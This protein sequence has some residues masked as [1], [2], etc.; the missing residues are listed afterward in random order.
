MKE[1]KIANHYIDKH[2]WDHAAKHEPKQ[3]HRHHIIHPS[4]PEKKSSSLIKNYDYLFLALGIISILIVTF[5]IVQT[6]SLSSI[7]DGKVAEAKEA[8]IPA[9]I[10]LITIN[11]AQCEDCF[12]ISPLIDSLKKNNVKITDEK[13]LEF[14]SPAAREIIQKYDLKKIPAMLISGEIDK[15]DIIN[16]E[17]RDGLLIFNDPELPYTEAETGE[18]LGLVSTILLHDSSCTTCRDL[19]SIT[20]TLTQ[21]G[22][23][24]KQKIINSSENEAQ[25]L[26]K[27]LNLEK[28]PVFLISEDVE[29]YPF[30]E[31][32]KQAGVTKK[33]EYYVFESPAPYLD[34]KTGDLRGLVDLTM[35]SDSAC[36]ECYDVNLHKN[37]FSQIGFAIADV[38]TID[39]NSGEG[40]KLKNRYALEKVPTVMLTG[41]IGA[42]VD[43]DKLWE[44]VGT[45]DDGTYIFRNIEALGEGIIY[46][47]LN[48]GEI[49]G[50]TAELSG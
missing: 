13:E 1:N 37:L 7:I 28:L 40:I 38:K 41:D 30:V 18:V 46:H 21:S 16:M 19:S 44:Q 49:V 23:T 29:A 24:T 25:E 14:D 9:N 5:N 3:D 12:S 8:A 45:I 39:I 32:I 11:N 15:I 4:S 42:Y 31:Q 2:E 33:N 26:I 10:Q 34:V 17:K 6:A 22:I 47:N 50:K 35:I 27:K 43:F 20:N 36:A 48:S